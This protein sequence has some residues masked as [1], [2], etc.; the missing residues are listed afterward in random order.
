V[1]A[2]RRRVALP[3]A[4]EHVGQELGLYALFITKKIIIIMRN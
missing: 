4:V 3:E 1:D 2:R